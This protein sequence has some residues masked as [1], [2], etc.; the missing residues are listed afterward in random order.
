MKFFHTLK[1][2]HSISTVWPWDKNTLSYLRSKSRKSWTLSKRHKTFKAAVLME[3]FGVLQRVIT[4]KSE[5]RT[6]S[7]NPFQ[8]LYNPTSWYQKLFDTEA[9]DH[10]HGYIWVV[11]EDTEKGL[12]GIAQWFRNAPSES[13][14]IFIPLLNFFFIRAVVVYLLRPNSPTYLQMLAADEAAERFVTPMQILCIPLCS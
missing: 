11:L 14:L 8:Q 12:L 7:V 10:P 9:V 6:S 2:L 1:C 4:T 5:K 13:S 3:Y